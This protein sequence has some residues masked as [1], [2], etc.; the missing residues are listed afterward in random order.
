MY[1]F[2]YYR[3]DC[4][5]FQAKMMSSAM[6]IGS[7]VTMN[8]QAIGGNSKNELLIKIKLKFLLLSLLY[9]FSTIFHC[10]PIKN[11]MESFFTKI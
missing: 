10:I 3:Y 4:D 2:E 1:L 11:R 9:F 6:I 5:F 8:W 7:A